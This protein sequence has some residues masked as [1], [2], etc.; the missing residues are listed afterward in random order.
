LKIATEPE[1]TKA[2]TDHSGKLFGPVCRV[3]APRYLPQVFASVIWLLFPAGMI[4]SGG[5]G[6]F[7]KFDGLFRSS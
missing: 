1:T 5:A 6:N 7:R 3:N 4:R 2:Q